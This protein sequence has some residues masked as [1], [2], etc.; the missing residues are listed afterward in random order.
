M[1]VNASRVSPHRPRPGGE[2]RRRHLP[3]HRLG[4][5]Q[6]RRPIRCVPMLPQ[7]PSGI[8]ISSR[9][10]YDRH[11]I[12]VPGGGL[13][14]RKWPHAG[15]IDKDRSG[16]LDRSELEGILKVLAP[17]SMAQSGFKSSHPLTC[18]LPQANPQLWMPTGGFWSP[19]GAPR[20]GSSKIRGGGAPFIRRGYTYEDP[21]GPRCSAWRWRGSCSTRSCPSW[22]STA[23]AQVPS[24]GPLPTCEFIPAPTPCK[25]HAISTRG[26][27]L[28]L[29]QGSRAVVIAE[30]FNRM[31]DLK[32]V[33][34]FPTPA[35]RASSARVSSS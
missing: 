34:S 19:L 1:A 14:L 12:F 33:P 26:V 35:A 23:T 28:G 2:R 21:G 32:E 16:T 15:R 5:A 20:F 22:T 29:S 24:L 31:N 27:V 10:R 30:F 9:C 7:Q 4:Q 25:H 17:G 11:A 8:L 6:A 18:S 13:R 3:L